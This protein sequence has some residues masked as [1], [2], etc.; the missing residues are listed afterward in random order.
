MTKLVKNIIE[1][2]VKENLFAHEGETYSEFLIIP[3]EKKY[4]GFWGENG[5]NEILILAGSLNKHEWKIV[6]SDSDVLNLMHLENANF[7]VPTDYECLRLF[8]GHPVK[9]ESTLSACMLCGEIKKND[10]ISV[11][12]ANRIYE[13]L[14]DDIFEMQNDEKYRKEMLNGKSLYEWAV[15]WMLMTNDDFFNLYGFNFNPHEY[16]GLYEMVR[17][18]FKRR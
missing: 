15:L 17:A 9:I 7:D 16:P 12:N 13:N 14:L 6:S 4:G 11:K 1:K 10:M 2:C 8:F 3:K 18:E 5:Y